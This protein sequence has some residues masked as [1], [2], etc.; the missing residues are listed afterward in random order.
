[1]DGD[2]SSGWSCMPAGLGKD[3]VATIAD[4]KGDST[5]MSTSLVCL[6]LLEWLNVSYVEVL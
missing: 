1:M 6:Q 3:E 2:S 4:A 5:L